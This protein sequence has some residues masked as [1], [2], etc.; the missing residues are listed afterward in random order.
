MLTTTWLAVFQRKLRH[1]KGR[2][3]CRSFWS[4]FDGIPILYCN[5]FPEARRHDFN[6]SWWP[7]VLSSK[8]LLIP[9]AP[10]CAKI[11]EFERLP[12]QPPTFQVGHP[13]NHQLPDHTIVLNRDIEAIGNPENQ[14][15]LT[16][17]HSLN[18]RN[19]FTLIILFLYIFL[20]F[21][22]PTTHHRLFCP[23]SDI[24]LLFTRPTS[25]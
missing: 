12:S 5:S 3:K 4:T 16:H 17:V 25:N 18:E 21:L 1:H 8:Y 23:H 7:R 11:Q 10:D 9:E 13:T 15:L 14:D 24:C 22:Y 6:S 20:R 19:A 2:K